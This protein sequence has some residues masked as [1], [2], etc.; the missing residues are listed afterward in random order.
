M[1]LYFQEIKSQ[2]PEGTFDIARLPE[3]TA[4]VSI[5]YLLSTLQ[6]VAPREVWRLEKVRQVWR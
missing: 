3:N 1:L 6:G 4:K 2:P 5:I